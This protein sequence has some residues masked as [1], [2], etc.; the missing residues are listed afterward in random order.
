MTVPHQDK[1]EQ[2]R[3]TIDKS[4][5]A[6]PILLDFRDELKHIWGKPWGAQSE[7]GKLREVMVQK[8]GPEMA[9]PERDLKWFG[10]RNDVDAKK[11]VEQ[12]QRFVDVLRNENVVVHYM[13]APPEAKGP[14]GLLQRIWATRDPGFVVNGGAI[15]N[16]MSLPWRRGDEYWWARRVMDI[17]CP[18]LYTV[19][20]NGTFES[21]NVVWLDPTHICIGRSMRTNQD[22]IDQVETVLKSVGVEEIKVIPIPGWLRNIEWPAGGFAHL[23]CVFAYVEAGLAMIYPPA[24]PF[25]FLEYLKQREV[26]MIEVPSPEGKDYACNVLALEPGK[27]VML[28]GFDSSRK[29]L[30]REGVDVIPVDMSEFIKSGGGPHCASAPLIRDPGP[31]I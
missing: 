30:E 11:A 31:K 4:Q 8:P 13:D 23:D 18:I 26:N 14:Y 19:R 1:V 21:G 29:M 25:D 3:Q 16:R 9:P 10:I 6:F 20:G 27:I 7:I 15:V 5:P 12:H 24:V 17:G 28:D 2:A 22:G